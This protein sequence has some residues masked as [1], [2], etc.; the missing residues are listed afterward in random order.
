ML[1]ELAF[2]GV[3]LAV[4]EERPTRGTQPVWSCP[5]SREPRFRA[6]RALACVVVLLV[7]GSLYVAACACPAFEGDIPGPMGPSH[8]VVSGA[9]ALGNGWIPPWTLP[10]SGNI[11]LL[12]GLILLLCDK[13]HLALG[14]GIAA[15]LAGLTTWA[16][17]Q[18]LL[19][20]YYLWQASLLALPLAALLFKVTW[21]ERAA[22]VV[23]EQWGQERDQLQQTGSSFSPCQSLNPPMIHTRPWQTL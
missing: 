7:I 18:T 1:G 22:E 23:A 13:D 3:V 4:C 2:V 12:A 19:V 5:M 17:F 16:F 20:G 21:P 11:F 10:W 14:F 8:R 6:M 9:F 15:A